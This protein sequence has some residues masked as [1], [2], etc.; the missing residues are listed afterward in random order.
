MRVDLCLWLAGA[1][2]LLIAGFLRL[3]PYRREQTPIPRP[4]T[5]VAPAVATGLGL[6]CGAAGLIWRSVFSGTW[7]GGTSADAL[8]LLASGSLIASLWNLS[9]H[10]SA[11]EHQE[12]LLA[13]HRA[14]GEALA[15]FGACLLLLP[16]IALAWAAGVPAPLQGA[17]WLP[18]L[19]S[20]LAGVGLGGWFPALAD[21]LCSL[22]PQK[23]QREE[24]QPHTRPGAQAMRLC[25][26][27]LT[28]AWLVG[29]VWSLTGYAVLWRGLPAELWLLAAWLLGGVYL[30][31]TWS[32]SPPEASV[33]SVRPPEW[34]LALL[35]AFGSGAAVLA[36]WWMPLL[37]S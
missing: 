21:H 17:P 19:W 32:F 3:W 30:C 4:F 7:P 23:G 27:A 37:L 2:I 26:P 11:A 28:A 15:L 8:A 1:V 9:A 6:A 16:A 24:E 10:R 22:R 33:G 29:V 14:I 18:W 34:V 13:R 12:S 36:A 35:T 31:A 25:Y 20:V 5:V